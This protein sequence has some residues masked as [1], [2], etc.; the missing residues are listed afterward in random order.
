MTTC[1]QGHRL[2]IAALLVVGATGCG[3]KEPAPPESENV[4]QTRADASGQTCIAIQRGTFGA[5]ADAQLIQSLANQNFGASTELRA[6]MFSGSKRE[7]LVSFDVS[8]IPIGSTV[9]SAEIS[10]GI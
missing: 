1:A 10:L 3:S 8:A 4:A 5:V 2:M 7:T 9:D 6:G